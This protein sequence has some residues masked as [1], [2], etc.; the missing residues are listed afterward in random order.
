MTKIADDLFCGAESLGGVRKK[1]RRHISVVIDIFPRS[2]SHNISKPNSDSSLVKIIRQPN[3][4]LNQ[5]LNFSLWNARSLVNKISA[6]CDSIMS[7]QTDIC[8]LTESWVSDKN[9]SVIRADFTSSISD[10]DIHSV[11][12]NRRRGGGI[13]LIVKSNISVTMHKTDSYQSF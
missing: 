6:V 2:D 1:S 9:A 8:I 3:Y 10:Y 7:N 13:A 12:R 11:P 5:C 4:A